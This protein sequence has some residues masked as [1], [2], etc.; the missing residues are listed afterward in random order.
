MPH[1]ADTIF[2]NANVFTADPILLHAEAVAVSGNRIIYVG[3]TKTA[4][5]LQAPHTHL[6]D[7][8]GCTLLPGFIDSHYHLFLGSLQ[9][10]GILLEEVDSFEM[11]A[12]TVRTFAAAHP[13][14]TWLSGSGLRYQVWPADE[15]LPRRLLDEL[16]ADRP[17][18]I[19]AFDMHT[20]WANTDALRRANLLST[21][22]PVAPNSEIVRDAGGLATG[23][24]RE[25][26]AYG[27]LLEL[28]PPPTEPQKYDLLQK[29]L[30]QAA[31]LGITSV[32]NM[33]GDAEQLTRYAA[34]ADV[35]EL[36]LR[37]YCPFD[38]KPDTPVTAL[39][40]AVAMRQMCQGD[41]V[42]SG[43]VKLFMDGVVENYTALVLDDYTG[44]PGNRG[45]ALF[46]LEHFT[47]MV[48]EADGLGMQIFVHAVGDGAVRRT[49]DGY[50]AVQQA[51]GKRDSRHRIE[52]IELLDPAD[53]ARFAKLGVIASMQPAHAPLSLAETDPWSHLVNPHRWGCAFPWQ[54]LREAGATLV[55]GSDWPVVSHSPFLGLHY[56]LNRQ[57]LAPGLPEQKQ[58]LT[59]ALLA[60]TRDA[61]YA[62][63]QEQQKG[64]LSPGMLADL[65]LLSDDIFAL[66]SEGIA[67]IRP[68]LTMCDGR[69]VFEEWN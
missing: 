7:G 39:T 56:A 52:H 63:F 12:E 9:L 28:I 67:S 40:E 60:Y 64:Q 69:V 25:P 1:L 53:T 33:D 2:I 36:T 24:L 11:F 65:V 54:T 46:S 10:G 35:G 30:A 22:D 15:R 3:T 38:I 47:R 68:L 58:S 27:P 32:H 55:F 4:L 59:N 16:V 45:G 51:N 42:R 37:V 44:Q 6:I 26:G 41:L 23:E 19:L 17:L 31:A 5:E 13:E 18:V 62:E 14:V 29:G 61:A 49:L 50:A 66:P 34:L 21:G 57:P 20:A 43:C 48:T 8:Q